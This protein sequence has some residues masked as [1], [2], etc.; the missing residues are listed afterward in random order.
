MEYK[1]MEFNITFARFIVALLTVLLPNGFRIAIA[2]ENEHLEQSR[3]EWNGYLSRECKIG[4]AEQSIRKVMGGKYRDVGMARANDEVYSLLFLIDDYHQIEFSF[5]R[6]HKLMLTPTIEPKG[7]WLRLP[8]GEV[9]SM[10]S[11]TEAKMKSKAEQMAIQYVVEHTGYDHDTLSA[12]CRR[13]TK[14]STWDAVV[15]LKSLQV[16]TPNFLLEI[17]DDGHVNEIRPIAKEAR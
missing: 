14:T 16:D 15:T 9:L 5:D 10:P 12:F 11:P 7:Q 6:G 4:A 3:M 8:N 13:S 2:G 1:E 17:N